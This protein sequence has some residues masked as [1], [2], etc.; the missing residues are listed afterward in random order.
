MTLLTTQP[1]VSAID[2]DAPSEKVIHDD[3]NKLV[4]AAPGAGMCL[5]FGLS[6]VADALTG[7]NIV[8]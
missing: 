2:L 5:S 1:D 7:G 4:Y 3:Y 8:H 6:D